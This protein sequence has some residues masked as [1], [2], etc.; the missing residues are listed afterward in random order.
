MIDQMLEVGGVLTIDTNVYAAADV[1]GGLQTYAVNSASGYVTLD[2]VRIIDD[3]N[4]KAAYHLYLFNAAPT[5]ILDQAVLAG[6]VL[7]DLKALVGVVAIAAADQA[8]INGNAYGVKASLGLKLYIPNGKLYAYLSC[9][10][11]PTFT[12]ATD[13]TLYLD[14]LIG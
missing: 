9:D 6:L 8:T 2:S 4:E 5:A 12:A 10:A 13:L 11:T 14:L 1:V 3:D 7:A